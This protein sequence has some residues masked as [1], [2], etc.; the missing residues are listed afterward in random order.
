MFTLAPTTSMLAAVASGAAEGIPTTGSVTD[1]VC[2]LGA[3]Y[4]C[5]RAQPAG[6]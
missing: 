3:W 5:G 4:R 6:V 2:G 1:P